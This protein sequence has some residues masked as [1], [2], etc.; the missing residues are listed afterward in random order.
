V[1]DPHADLGIVRNPAAETIDLRPT[2]DSRLHIVTAC[3]QRD[4]LLEQLIVRE[5]MRARADERH[6]A[7]PDV[8]QLR[9]FIDIVAAHPA[10]DP[11]IRESFS[12]VCVT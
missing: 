2:G 1:L 3:I 10:A 8:Q 12:L 4:R 7:A 11:G 5:R 6:L 9:Q